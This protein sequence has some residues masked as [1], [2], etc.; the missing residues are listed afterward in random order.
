MGYIYSG[1]H[2]YLAVKYL[3][4]IKHYEDEDGWN[5]PDNKEV[6]KYTYKWIL[7][8]VHTHSGTPEDLWKDLFMAEEPLRRLCEHHHIIMIDQLMH[9]AREW[10]KSK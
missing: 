1:R 5:Y 10:E 8:F 2:I 6:R 9:Y 3:K 4:R 7:N